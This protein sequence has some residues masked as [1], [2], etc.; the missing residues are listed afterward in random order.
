MTLTAQTRAVLD[1]LAAAGIPPTST[2]T[3]AEAREASA[4]RRA[5]NPPRA[6]PVAHVEDREVAGPDGRIPVRIYTPDVRPPLA[7]EVYFHGGGWVVGDLDSH[8]H[9][10]RAIANR[11]GCVVVSVDYRLAPEA[12]FP[13]ALDDAYAATRWV[14]EHADELGVDANRLA[15]AGDS[16]GGNLAAAVTLRA[17]DRGAPPIALQVLVYP[18]TDGGCDTGSYEEFADGFSLARADMQWFWD[19]YLGDQDRLQPLASP[20]RAADL[21]GLPPALVITAGN[22]PL[23]DEG[24]AY[25]AR[26]RDAGVPTTL[27]RY[28]GVIHGFFGMFGVVDESEQ[29]IDQVAHALR[30]ELGAPIPA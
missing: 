18:V 2:L 21:R 16:A 29:A 10:C 8:D 15:V 7:V 17:R 9:V 22:D 30:T 6:E 23:R 13:A 27:A 24:E 1:Q 25:A 28:D 11:A 19:H 3:P 14:S 5:L 4:Q 12:R 20:L 26:L